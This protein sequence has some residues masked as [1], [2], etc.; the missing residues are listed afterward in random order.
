[1]AAVVQMRVQTWTM[2]LP[3]PCDGGLGA[4]QPF[5]LSGETAAAGFGAVA[6]AVADIAP[7]HIRDA[8]RCVP[9]GVR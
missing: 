8:G 7:S 3:H 4:F 5:H 1:M 2:Q 9:L 6:R